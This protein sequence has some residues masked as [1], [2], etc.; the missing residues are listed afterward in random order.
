MASCSICSRRV[1]RHA[2]SLVCSTCD[3]IYHVRCLPNVHTT[4]SIYIQRFQCNW[5]CNLCSAKVFPFNHI[6]DDSEFVNAI[7]N[8]FVNSELDLLSRLREIQFYPFELN[9]YELNLPSSDSDPD[10]QYFNDTTY[11]DSLNKCDYLLANDFNKM[12]LEKDFSQSSISM[13]HLNI[14][15]LPKH[16]NEMTLFMS[17][18]NVQFNFIGITETWLNDSNS[19]LYDFQGYIHHKKMREGKRGGGVSVLVNEDF[20]SRIREELCIMDSNIE[21]IFIEVPRDSCNLKNNCLIGVVYRPPNTDVQTFTEKLA[22]ILSNIKN[23]HKTVYIMGDFNIDLLSVDTHIPSSDF[24]ELMY[25]HG[26]FPTISKPT[27]V[28]TSSKTLID[29]IFTNDISY[30]NCYQGVLFQKISDHFPIFLI[31][32]DCKFRKHDKYFWKRC[33]N[34]QTMKKF[35]SQIKTIDWSEVL[36][37]DNGLVAFEIFHNKY[38]KLYNSMFPLKRVKL[39][40]KTRKLWLTNGL[41]K[42]I[43]IKNS[44]Y[45]KS[46][47]SKCC[48]DIS[49]YKEYKRLLNKLLKEA[50]RS[51]YESLLI[52]NKANM[53]KLWFIIK[54]VINKKKMTNI[55]KSFQFGNNTTSDKNVISKKFN[56]YFVNIGHDLE[57]SIPSDSTD[58]LSYIKT[59]CVNSMAVKNVEESEV[60]RLVKTLKN[61]STGW[62]GIHS[63][64]IK[65]SLSVILKP[66]THVLNLSITQGTFPD[67]MKLARVIPIFKSGK[68]ILITNYRPVS[69]LPVYSKLFERLMYDRIMDFITKQNLLYKYQ[70]GFRNNHSTS[71]A[72]ITLIDNIMSSI[73]KGNM[74]LG[75]FLDFKKAFDTVNHSILL[76]KLH[77]YGIRGIAY[78]WIENYL[79]NR[80]QYVEFDGSESKKSLV[81]CGVPQG[82]ILGP[83]LFLIYINDI[84]TVS[85]CLLPII[86]ADDTN[87]FLNGKNLNEMI[88]K[89]NAE[90]RKLVKWLNA[91][92]LSL[93]IGK[94]QYM[95]FRSKNKKVQSHDDV[96]INGTV[97]DQV[98]NTKFLGVHIDSCFTWERHI[99]SVRTK[100]A[101]GIG[102]INKA[103]SMLG[104][105]TLKTLYYSFVYPHLTYCNEVWG[106]AAVTYLSKLWLLQKRIVRIINSAPFRAESEPLFRKLGFLNIYQI[107]KYKINAFMFRFVKGMLPQTFDTV[108][109]RRIATVSPT[110][111]QRHKL[112]IPHCRTT[113]YQNTIYYQGPH[114]WNRTSDKIDHFCS[115]HAF[116]AKLKKCLLSV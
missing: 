72:L 90:L 3:G 10:L 96:L 108:F 115:V 1:L 35:I 66:L 25:S 111:R 112:I 39:A 24:L 103:R 61:T 75:V 16:H 79:S 15:S 69:I 56:G 83:L 89:M 22:E 63:N 55:P 21:M 43:Q 97:V 113:A 29:N 94:T 20:D 77:R 62:D 9:D 6:E 70:F 47:K 8:T 67:S 40:Y 33:I 51:H 53:R 86:F 102:I 50:E 107:Y 65:G 38:L 48:E 14:R 74:V 85:D 95:I 13:M 27:R 11:V 37:C 100:T 18:L 93:N 23:E 99:L 87:V 44:L 106:K 17:G 82:S 5:L 19:D 46:M 78:K 76:Q 54:D 57:R 88:H 60:Q 109:R 104:I 105:K 64:V 68:E 52:S 45:I 30:S 41:K 7:T 58:P 71:M 32:N 31:N 92:K 59:D 116:K 4:D 28:T 98:N 42:A 114:E 12:T 34:D 73:D 49:T 36:Q 80:L 26:L 91:N 101:K 84:T 81:K 2:H 110:T